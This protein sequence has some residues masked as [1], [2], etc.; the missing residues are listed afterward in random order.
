MSFEYADYLAM[1]KHIQLNDGA[2]WLFNDEPFNMVYEGDIVAKE[3]PRKTKAGGFYTPT[4]TRKFEEAVAQAASLNMKST[5]FNFP[6]SVQL[7]VYDKSDDP[8]LR[9]VS[10]SLLAFDMKKDLDNCAKSILDG[11]NGVVWVD[12]KLIVDLQVR[13]RYA[14]ES[15]FRLRVSRRGLSPNELQNL[16]NV[17]RKMTD[18]KVTD[19]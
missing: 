8:A 15:G 18:G 1:G 5:P 4:R 16:L 14:A 7:V 2:P 19:R 10:R 6:V 12:D 17:M 13:R 3:R 11:L 9:A